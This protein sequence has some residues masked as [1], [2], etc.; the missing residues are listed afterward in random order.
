MAKELG[1]SEQQIKEQY[2]WDEINERSL[3]NTYDGFI[4]RELMPKD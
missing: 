2:T 3:F 4:D 1:Q